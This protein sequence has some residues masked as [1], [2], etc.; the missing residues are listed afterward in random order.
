ML[1]KIIESTNNEIKR[2]HLVK[3]CEIRWVDKHTSI[4]VFKQVFFG[5][6]VG[7]DYLV[8]SGDSETSGLAR[9]YGKALTDIDLVMPLI[10]VNRVFCI[11]KPSGVN[12]GGTELIYDDNQVNELYNE[13]TKFIELNEIDNCLSRTASRRYESVKDYF[14][15]VYRTFITTTIEELGRR[16]NVHQKLAMSIANLI[17]LYF[18]NTDFS[19]VSSLFQH[20]KDDLQTDNPNIHKVEFDTW[21]YHVRQMKEN[22]RPSIIVE[23]LKIMQPVKSFFPNIYILIQIYA[24]IPVS[25]AG[26]ERS[27]S[28]LKLIKTKLR[29]RTGGERL[30]DLAVI[31]IH[32]NIA[33]ELNIENV[34]DEFA[35]S[36]RKKILAM[37]FNFLF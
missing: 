25:V 30:S 32:K 5:V 26:A 27:F 37:E 18:V 12:R 19:N 4:I 15:D 24:L 21:K 31:N 35:K 34:I 16:F 1:A 33:E 13:F 23:T 7:L 11:T 6:I 22:E 2:R 8:E 10:I 20:Y 3:L 29:N 36:S 9:S 14:I 28:V 17:P